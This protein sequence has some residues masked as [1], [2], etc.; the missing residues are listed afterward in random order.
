M[1]GEKAEKSQEGFTVLQPGLISYIVQPPGPHSV[2]KLRH[3]ADLPLSS[4]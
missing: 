3:S 2:N 1:K 4:V